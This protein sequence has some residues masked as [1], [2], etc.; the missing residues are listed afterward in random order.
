MNDELTIGKLADRAGVNIQTIRYYQRR[1]LMEEPSKPLGAY[2]RYPASMAKRLHFI[3]RAQNLGFTLEEVKNLLLL[4][5][6]QN[7]RGTRLLAERKLAII[8]ER[9]DDLVRMRRMLRQLIAEC[10]EGRR[11][12]SCPII[13]TLAAAV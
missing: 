12:R 1:G 3:K 13:A 5:D 6:G 7:C 8:Q 2:R 11:P 10:A 4:E 9:I